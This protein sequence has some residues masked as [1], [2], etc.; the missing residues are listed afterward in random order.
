M[1]GPESLQ[2]APTV[3]WFFRDTAHACTNDACGYRDLQGEFDAL[4]VRIVAVGPTEVLKLTANQFVDLVGDLKSVVE[5]NF[6]KKVM[7]AVMVLRK[8]EP[9]WAEAMSALSSSAALSSSSA[10]S[11][12]SSAAATESAPQAM[13]QIQRAGSVDLEGAHALGDRG[14]LLLPEEPHVAHRA[15]PDVFLLQQE[16]A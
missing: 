8:S 13:L 7:E 5:A 9:S 12:S 15:D 14:A 10:S 16:P 4:G 1:H 2:G 6:K 3:V 11:E